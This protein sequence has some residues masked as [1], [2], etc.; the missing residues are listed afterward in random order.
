MSEVR[1]VLV[2]IGA[3]PDATVP[4]PSPE[5]S[6]DRQLKALLAM[7]SEVAGSRAYAGFR[8]QAK[9]AVLRWLGCLGGGDA[10]V[11]VV[12]EQVD[13]LVLVFADRLVFEQLKTKDRGS[14]ST[15]AVCAKKGGLDSLVRSYKAA[16]G[17]GLHLTSA[18]ELSLEGSMSVG[19]ATGDF[20]AEPSSAGE[21][22]RDALVA[23]G[24]PKAH[25]SDFL[26]RLRFR[27][28]VPPRATIDAVL[29]QTLGALWPS[30]SHPDRQ[31]V[32]ARLVSAAEAAQ[33]HDVPTTDVVAALRVASGQGADDV[34][35]RTESPQVLSRQAL[36]DLT[37]PLP[38]VSAE[39]VL[40][41]LSR[42]DATSALELKLLAAGATEQTIG[43][44]KSLR[45]QADVKRQEAIASGRRGEAAVHDLEE[46][47][48]MVA[49][50]KAAQVHLHASV[51]GIGAR[52]AEF[53]FGEL[54][55]NVGA[56]AALDHEEVMSGQPLLVL[57]LL[58][59]VS[60]ECRFWWRS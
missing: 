54:I 50:A 56:L 44:A 33:A 21:P 37:P 55:G 32:L 48:L 45:A 15:N 53:V 22:I 16:R 23:H 7:P 28:G 60:D 31:M 17:V 57:G 1:R 2:G 35:P 9:V 38:S 40:R 43:R 19:K 29:E 18:F 52:P 47:V 49:E 51:P 58:C 8:W 4:E 3:A 34:E 36:I 10:P 6:N 14:W 26:S 25:M 41:R 59:Q 12:C 20:F 42:G 27:S 39:D 46:R 13:D 11:A 5:A 24:L 30:L